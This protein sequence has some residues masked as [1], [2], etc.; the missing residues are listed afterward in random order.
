MYESICNIVATL[1]VAEV[2]RLE[3]T[4]VTNDNLCHLAPLQY[5]GLRRTRSYVNVLYLRLIM[6]IYVYMHV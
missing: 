1:I 6:C 2:E 3:I 5:S 4:E